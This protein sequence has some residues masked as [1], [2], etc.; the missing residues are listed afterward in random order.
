[1]KGEANVKPGLNV[2]IIL[3]VDLQKEAADIRSATI[4]DIGGSEVILS[5]TNPPLTAGRHIGKDLSVTYLIKE[6]NDAVRYGFDGKVIDIIKE[7]NLS[8][9]NAVPAILIKKDTG[10]KQYDLRMHYRLKPRLKD[11][12]LALYW[13]H[14]KVNLV[15]ISMGGARFCYKGGRSIEAGAIGKMILFMDGRRF[16]MDVR[17]WA[18]W[19]PADAGRRSD[20]QYVDVQFLN[21]D[22]TCSHLLNLKIFAIQR[23]IL[24]K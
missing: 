6:N 17:N 20:W 23:E 3:T 16:Q 1:M 14:E 19:F 22:K 21:M 12:S 8:S 11:V 15:D 5:Q 13:G 18:S 10:F 24:S 7:Y 2:T 9:L 4:Y